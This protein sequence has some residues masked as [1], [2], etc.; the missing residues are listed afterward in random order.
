M[1]S[2]SSFDYHFIWDNGEKTIVTPKTIINFG[3]TEEIVRLEEVTVTAPSGA[4]RLFIEIHGTNGEFVRRIQL[5]NYD[6]EVV[7]G[8]DIT[9]DPVTLN[10]QY[11]YQK[12]LEIDFYDEAHEMYRDLLIT[13][14]EDDES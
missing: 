10:M 8:T 11:D 9:L 12:N 4:S 14:G 6:V 5:W 13:L 1:A 3:L 7:A 2:L